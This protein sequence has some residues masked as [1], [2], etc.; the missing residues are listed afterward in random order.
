MTFDPLLALYLEYQSNPTIIFTE[1]SADVQNAIALYNQWDIPTSIQGGLTEASR[2]FASIVDPAARQC[3][4]QLLAQQLRSFPE[5]Y[6]GELFDPLREFLMGGA[7]AVGEATVAALA[8]AQGQFAALAFQLERWPRAFDEGLAAVPEAH[9]APFKT[10]FCA[11]FAELTPASLERVR[12]ARALSRDALQPAI[13][14]ALVPD[15]QVLRAPAAAALAQFALWGDLEWVDR[16]M[17]AVMQGAGTL[18]ARAAV[19][20]VLGALFHRFRISPLDAGIAAALDGW[21]QEAGSAYAAAQPAQ[22]QEIWAAA[23][24]MVARAGLYEIFFI[25]AGD[26]EAFLAVAQNLILPWV[27]AP[28]AVELL[29]YIAVFTLYDPE[30]AFPAFPAVIGLMERVLGDKLWFPQPDTMIARAGRVFAAAAVA[31]PVQLA[32]ES[33]FFMA[34]FGSFNL[35]ELPHRVAALLAALYYSFKSF[36]PPQGSVPSAQYLGLCDHILNICQGFLVPELATPETYWL[37]Y[38]LFAVAGEKFRVS[39]HQVP[40]GNDP[41]KQVVTTYMDALLAVAAKRDLGP[42]WCSSFARLA[43]VAFARASFVKYV[44]AEAIERFLAY[45]LA[46]PVP[47]LIICAAFLTRE[48]PEQNRVPWLASQVETLHESPQCSFTLIERAGVI[49]SQLTSVWLRLV[50]EGL[51]L[52]DPVV[53][54]A[55]MNALRAFKWSPETSEVFIGA[56][57]RIEQGSQSYLTATL[58]N[59]AEILHSGAPAGLHQRINTPLY[60]R[61]DWQLYLLG[62][63]TQAINQNIQMLRVLAPRAKRDGEAAELHREAIPFFVQY[64]L[65]AGVFLKHKFQELGEHVA[66]IIE[67]AFN[68]LSNAFDIPEIVEMVIKT[69]TVVANEDAAKMAV[70]PASIWVPL[71]IVLSPDFSPVDRRWTPA[72]IALIRYHF[73]LH[74]KYPTGFYATL[75]NAIAQFTDPAPIIAIFRE[76]LPQ[77]TQDSA[78]FVMT[79]AF[80]QAYAQLHT[81]ALSYGWNHS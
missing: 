44:Q 66:T 55:A 76:S 7:P 33:G 28:D 11:A 48:I 57:G 81:H 78:G 80:A 72:I 27:A 8:A 10:A 37:F 49:P 41:L 46:A 25:Q 24:R 71:S 38:Y 1:R 67:T 4:L 36:T 50:T 56:I 68:T 75:E 17:D 45:C 51:N 32:G 19:F 39:C 29:D 21:L 61:T 63:A 40:V 73:A 62:I 59:A 77:V 53:A 9:R 30:R 43:S 23:A 52:E 22:F 13:V 14:Q 26:H 34:Q 70:D 54:T 64:F 42:E 65:F 16:V 5:F 47:E 79:Q 20:E 12:R 74:S 60:E 15:V 31:A 18:A 6:L 69:L 2:P 35:T 58:T 3:L